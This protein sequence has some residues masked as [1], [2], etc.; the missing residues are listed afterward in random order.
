[1]S[2]CNTEPL[3]LVPVVHDAACICATPD[4]QA[5]VI[6]APVLRSCALPSSCR[7][8][9][10]AGEAY[11]A[12]NDQQLAVRAIV[13]AGKVVPAQ[14]PVLAKIDT[15]LFHCLYRIAVHLLASK[16]V[17]QNVDLDACARFRRQRSC[18]TLTDLSG[19]IDICFEIDRALG[20]VDRAQHRRKNLVAVKNVST[21]LPSTSGGPSS[22]LIDRRNC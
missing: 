16:P 21:R 19:P 6:V 12:V 13:D 18:E 9:N 2:P 20:A 11:G 4:P 22:V 1:M 14:R 8:A 5:I 17:D 15:R 3:Y 10:A 7:N